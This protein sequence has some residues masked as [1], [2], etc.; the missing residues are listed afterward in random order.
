MIHNKS[1]AVLKSPISIDT[2]PSWD[3]SSLYA[4]IDDKELTKDL[5]NINQ[6]VQQFKKQFQNKVSSLSGADIGRAIAEFEN[7]DEML[8]KIISF[9]QLVYSEDMTSIAKGRFYQSMQEAVTEISS[10]L[11]FFTLEINRLTEAKLS[12]KLTSPELDRYSPWLRNIRSMRAHQ[13]SD[14][15]EKIL[16]EKNV[17]GRNAWIR[18]FDET[19]AGLRFPLDDAQLTTTEALD[20][21]FHNDGNIRQKA[22]KSISTILNDHV[23][24]FT[25]ITNTLAKDKEVE[26]KWRKFSKPVSFRNKINQVE[27]DVVQSL[28]A[29]V[30]GHYEKLSHR[31]Y[32][33][34]AK[35]FGTPHL[36]FWDRNAPLPGN[37]DKV[38]EWEDAK[39]IVLDA[40]NSFSPQLAKVGE[41]FFKENWIDAQVRPGKASGA[42]SH[43]TVAKAHPYILMN[44][45]GKLRDVMTLA[46]ELGHGIHQVL[47]SGQGHL[48]SETPLTLAETASVFG[49]MLTFQSL[50]ANTHDTALRRMLLASKI[51]DM[52]NTVI[53]QISFHEFETLVHQERRLGELTPDAISDIWI[54]VQTDSLGPAIKLDEEFRVFWSYIPHFIHSPFY[55]YAYAFGDCLVNSLYTVY[56]NNEVGFSKKYMK[57]LQAGG[58][59]QHSKLLEPFG[60]DAADPSFW[61]R[62]LSMIEKLIDDLEADSL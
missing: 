21:L 24:L 7:M 36:S 44:Y 23:R 55:V 6:K 46:H 9:A 19:I 3:L 34:K 60:L 25:L 49:E 57:M 54:K 29:S 40:Y 16:H 12:E 45:Q 17:A 15:L 37:Q 59:L 14:D 5:K 39:T 32:S 58:T 61:D 22:A 62:G 13:L 53:R 1:E 31:Y 10:E 26:D 35:W 27:D 18:L 56:R 4:S 2:L 47:A 11:L 52:I 30:T 38:I 33:L 50:L 42:F 51:E 41:Q 28:V 8:G 43:P 20:K 48:M